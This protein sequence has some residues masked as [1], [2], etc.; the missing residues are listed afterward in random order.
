MS[1]GS[2]TSY[3]LWQKNYA[4]YIGTG[5]VYD[6]NGNSHGITIGL[7]TNPD[8]S[9][10]VSHAG[11]M[12]YVTS[13]WGPGSATE[14]NGN[15]NGTRA[16]R[17]EAIGV[18]ATDNAM[19][20]GETIM[21]DR[22]PS[23][24]LATTM[25]NDIP[26]IYYAYY[27]DLHQAIRFRYGTLGSDDTK[28][29]EIDSLN[30]SNKLT[31]KGADDSSIQNK[32]IYLL[33]Q[34]DI[35]IGSATT[36][37]QQSEGRNPRTYFYNLT[38]VTINTEKTIEDVKKV[39]I[40]P[41]TISEE[42]GNFDQFVDQVDYK[43]NS[44]HG[45][46]VVFDAYPKNYSVVV[47][48]STSVKPG[49]YVDIDVLKG[50]SIADDVVVLTWYDATND[51]LMY[52]YKK[53]PCNDNDGYSGSG[54]GYWSTPIEIMKE[55]GEYCKIKIDAE[56]GVHIAAYNISGGDL[57]YAHLN[58]YADTIC[59]DVAR[60]DTCDDTGE[61][62]TLDIAK[63]SNGN[64]IPY[65]GYYMGSAKK[66]K[67]A[68]LIEESGSISYT[69]GSESEKFTQK[70]EVSIIPTTSTVKKDHVNVGVWKDNTGAIKNSKIGTTSIPPTDSGNCWGNGTAN[71]VLGYA[72][73]VGTV[74][75]IETA[76]MK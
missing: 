8:N 41:S 49:Y 22:F 68:Y 57:I 54:D 62:I 74:G 48:N 15:Y 70:W 58:N 3:S 47:S 26:T 25:H 14:K 51:A 21:E 35:I 55:A 65:I 45:S 1:N 23:L 2:T 63:S 43:G 17:L 37:V 30:N 39:K 71:P 73:R 56:G 6:E 20:I 13:L 76:Q 69:N 72:I 12:T 61:N 38:N 10:G 11:R 44:K 66:N 9:D 52:S 42:K 60:V 36:G 59:T 40:I 24:S 29:V 46:N 75:H 32:N 4:K 7:D 33:D 31:M 53:N 28:I 67:I 27:D 34:N 64:W 18:P 19:G 16:I 50:A 5:F